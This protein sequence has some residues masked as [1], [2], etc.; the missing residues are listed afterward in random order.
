MIRNFL[1]LLI[2]AAISTIDVVAQHITFHRSYGGFSADVASSVTELSDGKYIL[3]GATS[4]YGLGT[5]DIFVM[6]TNQLGDVES[7]TTYGSSSSDEASEIINDNDTLL[8]AGMS[9][10]G[11]PNSAK[12]LLFKIDDLGSLIWAK[13]Y[14]DGSFG[15]VIKCSDGNYLCVGATDGFGNGG[16]DGYVVKVNLDGDIMWSFAM[17]T[18]LNENFQSVAELPNGDFIVGGDINHSSTNSDFY[19]LRISAS[20]EILWSRKMGGSL[21]ERL[22]DLVYFNNSIYGIGVNRSFSIPGGMDLTM[23]RLQLDGSL[24]WTKGFNGLGSGDGNLVVKE[25]CLYGIGY[26]YNFDSDG[27]GNDPDPY[28]F[29]MDQNDGFLWQKSIEAFETDQ[30]YDIKITSTNSILV[31]GF[32]QSFGPHTPQGYDIN[33]VKLDSAGNLNCL[34]Q[35]VASTFNNP[36]FDIDSGAISVQGGDSQDIT[37]IIDDHEIDTTIQCI[38]II[39]ELDTS[40]SYAGAALQANAESMAYQW[41]DCNHNFEPVMGATEQTIYSEVENGNYAVIVSDGVCIDT[42]SC[43]ALLTVGINQNDLPKKIYSNLENTLV[44][45]SGYHPSQMKL[46]NLSGQAIAVSF[47]SSELYFGQITQGLYVLQ[48]FNGSGEMVKAGKIL[49]IE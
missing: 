29:K 27:G 35:E 13:T 17:G 4:S 45:V 8:I 39:C 19:L 20:G 6:K 34:I 43:Y 40:V 15:K 44:T 14:G 38:N 21:S 1:L 9:I 36:I 7:F 48:L 11:S 23:I 28:I 10:A 18:P 30:V 46:Y 41:I 5:S 25:N 32:T 3:T 24:V 26:S 2:V 33:F 16:V 42:S 49:I 47:K 22:N 37:L 12:A 31:V